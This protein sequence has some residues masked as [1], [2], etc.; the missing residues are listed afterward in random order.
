V[1]RFGMGKEPSRRSFAS[2]ATALMAVILGAPLACCERAAGPEGLPVLRGAESSSATVAFTQSHVKGWLFFFSPGCPECEE[3]K[4]S[5][6]PG[7]E[8][9][10][11]NI[12]LVNVETEDGVVRLLALEKAEGFR[13]EALSP[14]LYAQGHALVGLASIRRF[15]GAGS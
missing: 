14:I 13:F 9:R 3:V 6:L 11:E 15:F 12:E 4:A 7:L 10:G 2:P 5:V 1:A 8:A